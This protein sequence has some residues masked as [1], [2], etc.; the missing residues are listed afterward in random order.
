M[1][2][3]DI[4]EDWKINKINEITN[5]HRGASPRPIGDKK[6][7]SGHG[8]GW[9]RIS[10]VTKT[11]KYLRKTEQYLSDLGESKCVPVDPG[12]LIMSICATIGKPIIVELPACIHDGFVVF[13]NISKD[14]DRNYF[15]Y[16]L[17]RNEKK[18][19]NLKQ[20]GTQGNLN[21]SL[22]GR[23]KILL[24][25]LPEQKRIAEVLS[26]V[27][28]AIQRVEEAITQTERLKQGL[29]QKLLTEGIGHTEFNDTAIGRIPRTWDV[30]RFEDICSFHDPQRI[31]LKSYERSKRQG[32]Y[33][34]YGAQGII[35]WIDEY[36]F[37]GEYILLAED[38]ANLKTRILPVAFKASGKFWVNNH[39]HVLAVSEDMDIN[40]TIQVINSLNLNPSIVGS[41]QPKLNQS[42]ARKITIIKP[43]L[44][45]QK[46][47]AE[48][49]STVDR[50]LELERERKTTL[51]R[52]KKGLMND[53]LTG[54]KRV[55][56]GG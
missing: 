51:E 18:F 19:L 32:Q 37:D 52:I 1:T 9:I 39:A 53:L 45:E 11:Y 46:K 27:D 25:P 21:T 6:Y 17:Q 30:V 16:V 7:F 40:F 2:E 34:Y 13:R 36:I 42:E 28:D 43:S 29:M 12:D 55:K 56:V 3:I 4:P 24:P 50:K 8:R 38:G 14:V 26:T 23:T 33:P 10:D 20:T 22:V 47:I 49:L 5:V 15:F 35:D 44:S 41:A 31:P 54:R 48:I